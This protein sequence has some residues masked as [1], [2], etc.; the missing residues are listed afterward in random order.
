MPE[1]NVIEIRLVGRDEGL[2]RSVDQAKDKMGGLGDAAEK[3]DGS[4]RGLSRTFRLVAYNVSYEMSPALGAMVSALDKAVLAA[5]LTGGQLGALAAGAVLLGTGLTLLVKHI[6]Q[7]REEQERWNEVMLSGS[8]STVASEMA[9]ISQEMRKLAKE[10]ENYQ[11]VQINMDAYA[12]DL[13]E[14]SGRFKQIN[15]QL[16]KFREQWA[17]LQNIQRILPTM[18]HEFYD[19]AQQAAERARNMQA[20]EQRRV[21]GL[22]AAASYRG[23]YA[24]TLQGQAGVM[25]AGFGFGPDSPDFQ[26]AMGLDLQALQVRRRAIQEQM[27]INQQEK[28]MWPS[29]L[30]AANDLLQ[31]DLEAIDMQVKRL[32][33]ESETTVRA[34]EL[35]RA[36]QEAAAF[37]L[38]E[39]SDDAA[40]QRAEDT[41]RQ[42]MGMIR[43]MR[44][45]NLEDVARQFEEI[46]K[47]LTDM[48]VAVN[49][50]GPEG[51]GLRVMVTELER[52]SNVRKLMLSW[53]ER[54]KPSGADTSLEAMLGIQGGAAHRSRMGMFRQAQEA[55]VEMT[56]AVRDGIERAIQAEQGAAG[57]SL[58]ERILLAGRRGESAQAGHAARFG[59]DFG[60]Q[61]A[62]GMRLGLIQFEDYM[63]TFGENAARLMFG[64]GDQ[65]AQ[66]LDDAFFS[67]VMGRFDSLLDV[68]RNVGT[69]ILREFTGMS[70]KMAS[71]GLMGAAGGLFGGGG[72]FGKIFGAIANMFSGGMG[73]YGQLGAWQSGG[74]I[75]G[76]TGVPRLGILHGG[77]HVTPAGE[78]AGGGVTIIN[79]SDKNLLQS[80][81][82]EE[83]SKGRQVIVNDVVE[84]MRGNSAARRGMR[85][86]AFGG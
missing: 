86:Y 46:S 35:Q 15:E 66:G 76:P 25:R 48:Q 14:A 44:A 70:A 39:L 1:D 52:L 28:A 49:R 57:V 69:G 62:G 75:P 12:G 45:S 9:K 20:E 3:A 80:V 64:V 31:R 55:G 8:T 79:L 29:E 84:S 83:M 7:A 24:E 16:Q 27:R 26:R 72:G 4:Y 33:V 13:G 22:E 5:K 43:E 65:M 23:R 74:E 78:E 32:K 21:A 47:A 6:Q 2:N 60:E 54:E 38:P 53:E 51:Q 36:M 71:K 19:P 59:Q 17:S 40:P 63:G 77:E 68:A 73:G 34:F 30:K 56:Q 41:S 42:I 81:V 37:R 11:R 67:V 61:W 58:M 82:A 50:M 10:T 18:G 85:R